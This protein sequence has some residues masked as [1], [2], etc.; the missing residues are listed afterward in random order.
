MPMVPK[1]GYSALLARQDAKASDRT[2]HGRRPDETRRC[3]G[4]QEAPRQ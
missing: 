1:H 2:G 3:P 4:K